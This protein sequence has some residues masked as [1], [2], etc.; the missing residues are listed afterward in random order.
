VCLRS[1]GV[2]PL[3]YR[4]FSLVVGS[5]RRAVRR[6]GARHRLLAR[7]E[8]GTT[9][10]G[11]AAAALGG[12]AGRRGVRALGPA[13]RAVVRRC[14]RRAPVRLARG[15]GDALAHRSQGARQ[16]GH[17]GR[18]RR[19]GSHSGERAEHARTQPPEPGAG[20]GARGTRREHPLGR[21]R[22]PRTGRCGSGSGVA[23]GLGGAGIR[24][25]GSPASRPRRCPA[26][27]RS[28]RPGGALVRMGAEG[29]RRRP[30]VPAGRDP[31][32]SCRRVGPSYVRDRRAAREMGHR[33]RA[34]R[35]AVRRR[36]VPL[37][38]SVVATAGVWPEAG[39]HVPRSE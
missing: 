23:D 18:G 22:F 14:H 32:L 27:G 29:H 17:R 26:P 7:A 38:Q 10:C 6:R 16:G 21:A 34:C 33:H 13:G 8:R 37:P 31:R 30:R 15:G 20:Y 36:L 35:F 28:R 3:G 2:G 4:A 19:P 11:P 12:A 1:A 24:V 5:A 25:P 9:V 39:A